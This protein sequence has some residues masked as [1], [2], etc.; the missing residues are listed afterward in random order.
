MR[1][2]FLQ[3]LSYEFRL[4]MYQVPSVTQRIKLQSSLSF[5]SREMSRVAV[6]FR[7]L[8][9]GNWGPQDDAIPFQTTALGGDDYLL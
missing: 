7:Q 1:T 9:S 2:R 5:R 4:A 6:I 3:S 8:L